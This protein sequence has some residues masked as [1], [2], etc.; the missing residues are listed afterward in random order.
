MARNSNGG[1]SDLPLRKSHGFFKQD[2]GD[3]QS[4]RFAFDGFGARPHNRKMD[5]DVKDRW[6]T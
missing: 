6:F 2:N 4:I 3:L 5:S 1:K